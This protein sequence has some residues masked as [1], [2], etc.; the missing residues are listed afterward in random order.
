MPT[1]DD[2]EL[3]LSAAQLL[4]RRRLDSLVQIGL[5][6]PDTARDSL[7]M[8]IAAKFRDRQTIG[9]HPAMM[10]S[11]VTAEGR[12]ICKLTVPGFA[13]FP[14]LSEAPAVAPPSNDEPGL[15]Q[16]LMATMY[17]PEYLPDS[18]LG[19][20]PKTGRPSEYPADFQVTLFFMSRVQRL[21]HEAIREWMRKPRR[22]GP[23]EAELTR[24]VEP[25]PPSTGRISESV[26]RVEAIL[27]R[28]VREKNIAPTAPFVALLVLLSTGLKRAWGYLAR[29]PGRALARQWRWNV[30]QGVT[31]CAL[32]VGL[33]G[34]T[35]RVLPMVGPAPSTDPGG[36][37]MQNQQDRR[38][39]V[40]DSSSARP[41]SPKLHGTGVEASSPKLREG[42]TTAGAS[43]EGGTVATGITGPSA[44]VT[45]E[46]PHFNPNLLSFED[47]ESSIPSVSDIPWQTV[48]CFKAPWSADLRSA[49]CFSS[50]ERCKASSAAAPKNPA[51]GLQAP[52]GPESGR[53]NAKVQ[54]DV[55]CIQ[56]RLL[57]EPNAVF[58]QFRPAPPPAPD[59]CVRLWSPC[60]V[61]TGKEGELIAR[62]SSSLGQTV[63]RMWTDYD[64][65]TM[66]R[67]A[68]GGDDVTDSLHV[69]LPQT[70]NLYYVTRVV[71]APHDEIGSFR[72]VDVAHHADPIPEVRIDWIS[73]PPYGDL[74]R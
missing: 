66:T 60:H 51:D 46:M 73:T 57:A 11:E 31:F 71:C 20:A 44:T 26:H 21:S 22:D 32:A 16:L 58:R 3:D 67:T 45:T 42:V 7:E 40:G 25:K 15:G 39:R 18:G 36:F 5:R 23:D 1:K 35:S 64:F 24:A 13:R 62:V 59:H 69:L 56:A 61:V 10:A 47:S 8:A 53:I 19:A 9:S 12:R 6:V 63:Y 4:A 48:Y 68:E 74:L 54:V 52:C 38:P 49:Q 41:P 28:I 30:G 2:T 29:S 34:D 70:E 55:S 27:A 17:L 43:H 72:L 65:T 37:G 33:S 50:L 14:E